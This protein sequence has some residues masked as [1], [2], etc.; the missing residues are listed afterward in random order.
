MLQRKAIRYIIPVDAINIVTAL[1]INLI[2][3]VIFNNAPFHC[4]NISINI[5]TRFRIS[6]CIHIYNL[7]PCYEVVTFSC[8]VG[9]EVLLTILQVV[10]Y[11]PM[12][13]IVLQNFCSCWCSQLFEALWMTTTEA[14]EN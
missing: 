13:L 5:N 7:C 3:S 12:M 14:N 9:E 8:R 1:E 2:I 11:A 6:N 4:F 10:I